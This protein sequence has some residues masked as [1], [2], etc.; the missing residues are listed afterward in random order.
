[1]LSLLKPCPSSNF[2]PKL[3]S[4]QFIVEYWLTSSLGLFFLPNTG[5]SKFTG[6]NSFLSTVGLDPAL[7][8]V[9]M[10]GTGSS[11]EFC[12]SNEL[13]CSSDGGLRRFWPGDHTPIEI[14]H[15]KH[16]NISSFKR[17][18]KLFIWIGYPKISKLV[19]YFFSR[20]EVHFYNVTLT[21]SFSTI[22]SVTL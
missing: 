5:D 17:Q 22:K 3:Y 20:N 21:N 13:C 12:L 8:G 4:T 9:H 7:R 19:F 14:W 16:G 2:D 15:L 18:A 11:F 10:T 6:L 1:M